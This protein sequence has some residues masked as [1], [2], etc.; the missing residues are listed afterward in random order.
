MKKVGAGSP[1]A[2]VR[3]CKVQSKKGHENCEKTVDRTAAEMP[4][5][6]EE[7][8]QSEIRSGSGSKRGRKGEAYMRKSISDIK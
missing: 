5:G 1:K 2:K 8:E 3:A 4:D 7:E 6:E